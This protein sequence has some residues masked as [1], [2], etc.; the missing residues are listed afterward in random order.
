MAKDKKVFVCETCGYES[1]KYWGKCPDCGS[2]NTLYEM[3]KKELD[4]VNA[5]PKVF[6]PKV[7]ALSDVTNEDDSR[8]LTNITEFD[9]VLG[10]GIVKSSMILVGGEPG[11]G[12][13]TL[14]LQTASNVS[15][16]K[17]V[18]YASSEESLTQIKLRLNR[19]NLQGDNILVLSNTNIDSII[20]SAKEHKVDLL[21]VDSIQTVSS[22]E[23]SS[24]PGTITQVRECTNTLMNF[25]KTTNTS[26]FLVGHITKQGTLAGPK[27]IEHM[28]DTV[29]YFENEV[30]SDLRILR[31]SK[32][33]FGSSDEIGIFNMTRKG[34]VGVKNPSSVLLED[35]RNRGSGS[36]ICT[37]MEGNRA[38]LVEIQALAMHSSFQVP[39]RVSTG[40][41]YNRFV[42]MLAVIEKMTNV[43]LYDLDI[44]LNV[45]GGITFRETSA[46]L[47]VICAVI[48]SVLNKQVDK[49]TI[50]LGEVG[51]CGEVRKV[52]NTYKR[53]KEA[54]GLGFKSAIVPKY[55]LN[56][57]VEDVSSLN[58][59]I[60]EVYTIS[61]VMR[62]VF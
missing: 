57:E 61:D 18:L 47:G 16:T 32:N 24:A 27:T 50:I 62:Y 28:V 3:S 54:S 59:D 20:N 6:T 43:K 31:L 33:R 1:P 12:K 41:T 19:L 25:A 38:I 58:M 4:M 34:L 40:F 51:L 10:G 17:K 35:R 23:I 8:F 44:Y 11:I 21:I 53:L 42:V 56:E 39:R 15:K 52:N 55:S 7:K 26:I 14:L 60:K 13:S 2:W 37:S 30:N 29:M 5:K 45:V 36:V 46:D 22:D 49:D 48:S 9:N